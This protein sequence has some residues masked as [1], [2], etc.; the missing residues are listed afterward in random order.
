MLCVIEFINSKNTYL[1][2][3]GIKETPIGCYYNCDITKDITKAAV[4][5]PAEAY[6]FTHP[7]GKWEKNQNHL[8]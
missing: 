8:K 3:E 2:R 6:D 5:S 7:Y 4:L 1:T